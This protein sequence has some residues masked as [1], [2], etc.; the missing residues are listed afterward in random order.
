MFKFV[1]IWI[2]EKL[3]ELSSHFQNVQARF[4]VFSV[5]KHNKALTLSGLGKGGFRPALC[6]L[7][8]ILLTGDFQGPDVCCKFIIMYFKG[9]LFLK[10]KFLSPEKLGTPKKNKNVSGYLSAEWQ[11]T[12]P[13]RYPNPRFFRIPYDF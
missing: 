4:E 5:W 12:L 13:Y 10:H 11:L 1:D 9:M 2:G 8:Y 7:I 3:L 6:I